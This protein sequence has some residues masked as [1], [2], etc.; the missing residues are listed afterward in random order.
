MTKEIAAWKANWLMR[1]IKDEETQFLNLD[2]W[3]SDPQFYPIP[4]DDTV[5]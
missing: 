3:I 4:L 5:A 2:Q 1:F